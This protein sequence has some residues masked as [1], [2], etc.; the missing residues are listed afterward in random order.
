MVFNPLPS[1]NIFLFFLARFCF[2]QS[3]LGTI[4]LEKSFKKLLFEWVLK[5]STALKLVQWENAQ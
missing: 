2:T 1:T 5:K 4:I 3:L